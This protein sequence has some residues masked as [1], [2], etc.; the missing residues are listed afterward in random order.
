MKVKRELLGDS[1]SF[2]SYIFNSK[3]GVLTTKDG[4]QL[5]M[6]HRLR[7]LFLILLKNRDE[8][9]SKTEL[10]ELAWS[11]T[12][13]SDQ[14]VP[15]AVSDLR[16]FFAINQLGDLR[17]TTIRKLGYRLE[18][19]KSIPSNKRNN[20]KRMLPYTFAVVILLIFLLIHH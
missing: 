6:E 1:I 19:E 20:F 5:F 12:I 18:I 13:V 16:K 8:F 2:E 9:L 14:S 4:N 15:K 11:G 17:I 10:I 3:T 7:D